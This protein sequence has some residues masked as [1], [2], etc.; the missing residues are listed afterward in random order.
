MFCSQIASA[1]PGGWTVVR[2]QAA[3]ELPL[4]S[5]TGAAL[6]LE[7]P[8]N[9][10]LPVEGVFRF[11][12]TPG[13]ALTVRAVGDP[14]DKPLLEFGF[15][16]TAANQAR[17]T[18]R[19]SGAP[20]ATEAKSSRTWS[21]QEKKLGGLTYA[22]RFLRVRNLWDERDYAEI[23]AAY[24]GLIPFDEK[25][26]TLRMVLTADGRQ[27]WLDDRLLAEERL[28]TPPLTRWAAVLTQS[29]ALLST[30]VAAHETRERFL[31]LV[32]D[33][34]SHLRR[35]TEPT[36]QSATVL[37]SGTPLRPLTKGDLD[38]GETL[39]RYRLTNGSG[40]DAGYVKATNAWP[41]AF[42]V[43]P[44]RL[45]F[46]VPYRNYQNAWLLA[47]VDDRRH[48]VPAGTLRFFRENAGYPAG[49][50]F[51]IS[52]EAERAGRVIRLDRKTPEGRPLFLVKVPLD[53]AGLYGLRDMADEFLEFELS[54]PVAL[55]RSY[56]DPI[57]YG[58]HPAG[59][60]STIRVA[61]ITLEEA[62]F[63]FQVAPRE[64]HYVF[65]QP[66]KP[67]VTV[68]VANTSARA[69]T[70]R[71][72]AETA[73]YDGVQTGTVEERVVVEPGA[74]KGADLVL[75]ARRLGWHA[76]KVTVESDG[77]RREAALSV[78]LL[79]P[80]TRTYGYTPS[81][82]RFGTW[83]LLGHYL[84]QRGGAFE[85]NE[86][87][88]LLCRRLGLRHVPLHEHF[89]TPEG[90]KKYDLLPTGP[91]SVGRNFA[92]YNSGQGDSAEALKQAVQ[93]EVAAVASQARHFNETTYYYGGEWGLSESSQYAPWPAYTGDGDR[94]VDDAARRNAERH[95][96]IF[97]AIGRALRE[98]F[99][100]TKLMLQWGAPAG[101]L[102]YLR[103]GMPRDLVDGF[104]LDAPMFE[105]LPEVSNVTGSINSLWM[106]REE[107]RRLGWPRLPM[108]WC[109]GPFFPTNP[110]A[111][112]ERAQMDYQVR[113]LLLGMAYGVE[114][115]R[116]G[117]V[118]QDAGNY[119]GAEHYGAGIIH[120]TPLDHPKPAVAA[121]A[122]MT[123]M[124]CGFET[125]GGIDT[126]RLT[127]YC[128]EFR[129]PRDGAKVYALW[130]VTGVVQARVK[131]RG[132][133]GTITDAMG[134]AASVAAPGGILPMT[135]SPSPV[136]LT[137]VEKVESFEFDEPVYDTA[138]ARVTRPLAEMTAARWTYD[139][140]EDK[141]YAYNHFGIRRITSANLK[142]E[143]GQ[144]E[145]DRPD[146]TAI[147]LAVEPG[148][149][150]LATRYGRLILRTPAPIPGK[151]S[152]LGLWVKGNSSWGRIAYQC[153]DAKGEVWTSTGTKNDWNCDDTHGWS[154]VHFEGWRYVRFPLPGNHP[155]DAA[156]ELETTWWGSRG[157]DGIVDLPLTLEAI[158]VEARNEVPVLGEMKLVPKRSYKLSGLVAEYA[159][160]ADASEAAIAANRIR[161]AEAVWA[162]PA[163]NPIARLAAEGVGIAPEIRAFDEPQH[164]NDGQRMHVRFQQAPGMKYNLYV[165]RH[166]D[167][168]GADLIRAGVEDNQLV[169]GLRAETPMFLFLTAVNAERKESKPSAAYRLVTHDRFLEK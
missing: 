44:A 68:T 120:R 57:Y 151:A 47:W 133:Q 1:L 83:W 43:D 161:M 162:G 98:Q 73:S 103:A 140:S 87:A 150:P 123:S 72:R 112:S 71:V 70:A 46:R 59:L 41:G 66:G 27:I 9:V 86:R 153:R 97:T 159:S 32:L 111:L 24:A 55:G 76:L 138:P 88:L 166:A 78:V 145:K 2:G 51:E 6:E 64:P 113:Y 60:P 109:E 119:Y 63:G 110:G 100:R 17:L 144:G 36:A 29:L 40:P 118:P 101:T 82:T 155:Y 39:N 56:P 42:K 131:V 116:S 130:R 61:A 19:V 7:M 95:V 5:R 92:K 34:Y 154:Y 147:T 65:E 127:T 89:F 54:K 23:G 152:A 157:G 169:T 148:D 75:D 85:E 15:N 21:V 146:A 139:G 124:L 38:L 3:E 69:L 107:A 16:L 67:T 52:A 106:V 126:G 4:A 122:T 91:H 102:V 136:W 10:G 141:A 125:V 84:A 143:F 96:R 137:G 58:Y 37:L 156:R 11:R 48:G 108:S 31:P 121:V 158:V 163:E 149:R 90:L 62:P 80:N 50:D 142:A 20:M 18:A 79:P 26:F 115:F 128:L 129:R 99:P 77:Q 164:W 160:E 45:T 49:A 53:T 81:E 165:S 74:S 30:T 105:L 93:A 117:I 14:K 25:V 28:P 132:T 22:W 167:G 94:P 104:A 168:R 114:E 35:T 8:D 135:I 134:N 33:D 12:A 13:G